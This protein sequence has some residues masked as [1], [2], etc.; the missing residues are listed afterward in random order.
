MEPTSLVSVLT[1][2]SRLAALPL[3]QATAMPGEMYTSEAVSEHERSHLFSRQWLC[4]GRTEDIPSPG[5]YL[6]F[7]LGEQPAV[8]IR[9]RDGSV[10]AFANV[11]RHRMMLLLEGS[12]SC[13]RVVCPYH[14][15][16]YG[17]DGKLV[18]APHMDRRPGFDKSAISLP[19]IRCETW[20]GWI[21][22]CQDDQAPSIES[23]L[24]G[25]EPLI[26]PY[27]MQ[28]YVSIALHDH[29]WETNWKQL[30]ENFMEGYHLP[31]AHKASVGRFFPVDKTRF[32]DGNPDPAFTFQFFSKTEDAPVG[33]AHPTNTRLEGE[34]R[35]TSIL[36][37]IFPS[38]MYALAPDHLWYLSL[39]PQG[40]GQVRIRYGA[41][42]A[43]EVLA[44]SDDPETL[45]ANTRGFLDQ[46]NEEDRKVVEGIYRG[47]CAPLSTP[48]PLCWLEREN[49]EFTQYLARQLCD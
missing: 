22:L 36:P 21:Y 7:Q 24:A 48:G 13:R 35:L 4:A 11:C 23:Q 39:Q 6:C 40:V 18:G 19:S 8:I 27:E 31:V 43:P 47:A 15:W 42:L 45:I 32:T 25:L 2:L 9:Q 12:G 38:H 10:L 34:Q 26:A 16:T 5:D 30:T 1:A 17:L 33:V 41:A 14:A 3:E 49:H 29:V 28:N 46:V 20:H 37:T 44:A